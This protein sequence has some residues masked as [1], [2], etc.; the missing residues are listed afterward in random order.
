MLGCH[1]A[2]QL[3][4]HVWDCGQ[5]GFG[6]TL[7]RCCIV[8]EHELFIHMFFV[9]RKMKINHS[10]W[11]RGI[12]FIFIFGPIWGLVFQEISIIYNII[13]LG[14]FCLPKMDLYFCHVIAYWGITCLMKIIKFGICTS[15]KYVYKCTGIVVNII[16]PL[17]KLVISKL[18]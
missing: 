6:V 18:R 13:E 10:S 11:F 12:C 15:T 9:C 1:I 8:L 2:G 16:C 5:S 3:V 14:M 7:V 17:P 4:V